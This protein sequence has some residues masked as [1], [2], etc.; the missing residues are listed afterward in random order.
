MNLDELKQAFVARYP[1]AGEP[2]V[3]RIP[4]RVNLMG[5]HL[6]YNGLPVLPMAIDRAIYLAF[7]PNRDGDFRL[8]NQCPAF[9]EA[10]FQNGA[11]IAPSPSGAWENYA[12]A[13]VQGLNQ[14]LSVEDYPGLDVLVDS[15]L[16]D[17]AGLS[18][19]SA[20]VV[21]FGMAYL[22]ALGYTLGEDMPRLK[23]AGILAEAEHYVGTAGGGMDQTAILMGEAG[24]AIRIN[25]IPFQVDPV[26]LP[27]GTSVIVCDS[28][29]K[30]TKT[31]DAL[32]RYN[33]GPTS[34]SLIA[35][36]INVHLQAEFG[37]EFEIECLGELWYGSLCFNRNEV[38]QL[39]DT[40]LP[41]PRITPPEIAARLG[42][43]EALVR[44]YWL[45]SMPEEPEGL[46][47]QARARHVFNEY[48][49]VMEGR[50]ALLGGD[51]KTFGN[52]M[53]GS[54]RSCAEDYGIST[55]ELDALC[56]ALREAGCL[57]A[58]LTGA[59]FGGAVVALAPSAHVARILEEV[60]SHYYREEM[61]WEGAIPA[62]CTTAGEAARYNS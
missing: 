56:D 30:A 15:D 27:D 9:N 2:F 5:E 16:P 6:D 24:S 57:G 20:L 42:T 40:V 53:N 8:A 46:P 19:S 61:N 31:G 17:S 59:G 48:Y 33:A 50:D 44:E 13:A 62:F 52:L 21:G 49:R 1:G 41:S 47:L 36:L 51:V 38:K 39:L 34:C 26:P 3:C 43:S 14:R 60:E 55:P 18:S 29:V 11:D 4:G 35:A 37:N 12:K 7:A 10:T 25:F 58:R 23:L 45:D 54:H 28:L 22:A 32:Q